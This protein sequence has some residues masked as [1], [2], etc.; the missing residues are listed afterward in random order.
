M[1]S[2]NLLKQRRNKDDIWSSLQGL[3]TNQELTDC[4]LVCSDGVAVC[5]RLILAQA[6]DLLHQCLR[7]TSSEEVSTII[8]PDCHLMDIN[9]FLSAIYLNKNN[10]NSM[11]RFSEVTRTLGICDE[12]GFIFGGSKQVDESEVKLQMIDNNC[13][14]SSEPNEIVTEIISTVEPCVV[15][16]EDIRTSEVVGD[17]EFNCVNKDTD[18]SYENLYFEQIE[19]QKY[20]C[21]QCDQVFD[22]DDDLKGHVHSAHESKFQC[23]LCKKE[24]KNLKF[25]MKKFHNCGLEQGNDNESNGKVVK[26]LY[27][28]PECGKAFKSEM[29]WR[30][31]RYRHRE[32]RFPCQQC[33][34]K[35]FF[36]HDYKN[37]MNTHSGTKDHVCETCGAKFSSGENLSSHRYWHFK[38]H[39]CDVCGKYFAL[40]G[41]LRVHKNTHT[42]TKPYSC[43][44]C[45]YAF[46]DDGALRRHIKS[47]HEGRKYTCFSCGKQF[48]QAYDLTRHKQK[49]HMPPVPL[50]LHVEQIEQSNRQN[51]IEDAMSPL[52]LQ[53]GHFSQISSKIIQ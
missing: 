47:V 50:P 9:N 43:S 6:S 48:T 41:K 25:H 18:Q 53:T 13:T 36:L 11:E 14:T 24:F 31:H 38:R 16:K 32:P 30:K 2:G 12:S 10:V 3:Y 23:I 8:L 44:H 4:C 34:K 37:H 19:L 29:S 20:P 42:N 21:C 27:I 28:C 45:G 5:H 49:E 17:F 1:E 39:Q 26:G 46:A 15:T 52:D 33:D 35:F 22:T 7:L 51:M 40:M